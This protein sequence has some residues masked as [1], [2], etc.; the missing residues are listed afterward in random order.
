MIRFI[1]PLLLLVSFSANADVFVDEEF[2]FIDEFISQDDANK[3]KALNPAKIDMVILNSRGG[4][5]EASKEIAFWV[6]H[7]DIDT[8]LDEQAGCYSGCSLI[9]Q[10]GYPKRYA[11]KNSILGFH[12]VRVEI[13]VNKDEK[14][15]LTNPN[16]T[17]EIKDLY[18]AYGMKKECVNRI[19]SLKWDAWLMEEAKNLSNC[20]VVTDYIETSRVLHFP[21]VAWNR[22]KP[23]TISRK[24]P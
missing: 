10:A 22:S 23:G 6:R 15:Y 9:F 17:K 1:F 18:R 24:D 3:I 4:E 12:P 5:Y 21:A 11:A 20:N 8:M 13:V 7:N 14:F 2:I 16:S 19:P